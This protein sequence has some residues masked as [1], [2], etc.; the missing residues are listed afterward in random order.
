PVLGRL[1]APAPG[2]RPP[3]L[4]LIVPDDMRLDDLP[5]MP[6]VTQQLVEA[7][8]TFSHCFATTPLCAPSRASMLRGQYAHN[9]GVLGNMGEDSGFPVF[10]AAGLEQSTIA[11]WL[12]QGGYRTGL[13]GKYL[14]GYRYSD[15]AYVPPGWEE[16]VAGLG[17]EEYAEFDYQLIENGQI[18]SYGH[19]PDDYLTDVL[20]GKAR[21]F[22]AQASVDARPFFLYLATYAPHAPSVPAPRH[23]GDFADGQAP[24][25]PS[26]NEADVRDKPA[27]V[28]AIPP[29]PAPQIA[30]LDERQR[31]RLRSLEAVDELVGGVCDA[32]AA[33][34]ALADTYVVF[35]SDNGVFLG[36]HRLP[37]GKNVPYDEAIGLPL[38][39]RGP[40]VAAAATNS[41]LV[42]NIDL[43]P[44]LAAL[45]GV[46]SPTFVDGRSLVPLL[47]GQ[48]PETGRQALLLEGFGGVSDD[49][50]DG[51]G[52]PADRAFAGLRT[53]NALYARYDTGEQELYDLVADPAELGNRITEAD[54]GIVAALAE[55]VAEVK[56]AAGAA[57]RELEDA[58]LTA[59]WP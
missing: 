43:A 20:A 58:P 7:G 53:A 13:I 18:V 24:R 22:I 44:T 9:H 23:A 17:N 4:I 5:T 2:T 11:T 28:Q 38:V 49:S 26:F 8:T 41:A 36:E 46:A 59:L 25:G 10:H 45:A 12:Q 14:N 48:E 37:H 1:P 50:V 52:E 30:K 39:V 40:G 15:S 42:A 55:R 3:N 31:D 6:R 16:W 27:W 21:E 47:V 32:V 56:T 34:V 57:C 33:A 54:P 19:S 51:S 29:M 35:T